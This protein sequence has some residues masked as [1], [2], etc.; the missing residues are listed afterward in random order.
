M[1]LVSQYIETL[2]YIRLYVVH[3]VCDSIMSKSNVH[4]FIKQ[5][6]KLHCYEY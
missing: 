2:V 3:Y 6:K 5:K 4:A 1:F